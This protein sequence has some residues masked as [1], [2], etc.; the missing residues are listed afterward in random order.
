MSETIIATE[1]LDNGL[2]LNFH[3]RGNRYFGDYHQVKVLVSITDQRISK[4]PDAPTAG[5]IDPTSWSRWAKSPPLM[6]SMTMKR[7]LSS[8]SPKS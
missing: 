7:V 8:M 1:K 5:E 4:V 2:V 6:Y 3:D